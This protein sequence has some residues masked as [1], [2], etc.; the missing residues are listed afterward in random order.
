[1]TAPQTPDGA[2]VEKVSLPD[3]LRAP[4]HA[5]DAEYEQYFRIARTQAGLLTW[6]R[7]CL[8]IQDSVLEDLPAA[9]LDEA[10]RARLVAGLALLNRAA[11]AAWAQPTSD[12]PDTATPAEPPT[13]SDTDQDQS[14]ALRR[15]R[16]GHQL[17]HLQLG[18]M[19]TVLDGALAAA[20]HGRIRQLTL[21]MDELV[22]LYD[23]ATATMTYTAAFSADA[24]RRDVR[25]TMEPP[26]LPAGFS[27][28]LN[29]EHRTMTA[30]LQTLLRTVKDLPH[31]PEHDRVDIRSTTAR[32]REAKRR[33]QANHIRICEHFVPDGVSLLQAH[34]AG[35]TEPRRIGPAFD[36]EPGPDADADE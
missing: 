3:D 23:A 33:N 31:T 28:R 12:P 2:P 34:L 1:M 24:Y 35:H 9:D 14:Y 20:R 19:L 18:R 25:P 17:F 10:E 5:S 22:I 32:L 13:R 8:Q 6:T 27:G 11:L 15:W 4:Q 21:A 30:Q 36:A 26:F 7:S 29:R 16:L